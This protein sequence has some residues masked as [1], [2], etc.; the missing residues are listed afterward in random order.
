MSRGTSP[1]PTAERVA[2]FL[3]LFCIGSLLAV[4][5]LPRLAP[6]AIPFWPGGLAL[7]LLQTAPLLVCVPAALRWQRTAFGV[8]SLLALIYFALGM[9]TLM[10]PAQQWA[11]IA[12]VGFALGLFFA[13]A[14]FLRVQGRRLAQEA[15]VTVSGRGHDLPEQDS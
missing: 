4:Y 5:G 11:G 6:D 1:I 8:L 15:S 10:D 12:E 14:T 3:T 9:W 13:S 2:H 7:L